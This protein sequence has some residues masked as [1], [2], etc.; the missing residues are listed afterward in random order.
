[1]SEA[2]PRESYLATNV[3][4]TQHAS[5]RFLNAVWQVFLLIVLLGGVEGCLPAHADEAKT[6]IAFIDGAAAVL[7]PDSAGE[8]KF[9]VPLK[10]SGTGGSAKLTLLAATDASCKGAVL[11]PKTVKDY[12]A[13]EVRIEPFKI[14]PVKLPAT[15][16]IEI[17][18]DGEDGSSSLKQVKLNQTY[19]KSG[20]LAALGLSFLVS[21]VVAGLGWLPARPPLK[22][23]MGS[24]AW[25]FAKSW[26]ST[27]TLVG[28]IISTALAL[29]ALPDLTRYASKSGY[30]ILALFISFVVVLAPF[31]FTAFRTGVL[32]RDQKTGAWT[33]AYEG[34]LWA[35][36]LSCAATIF[37]GITQIVVFFLLLHEIFRGYSFWSYSANLDPIS[38]N[39]GWVATL[40]LT[41]VLCIYSCYSIFLTVALQ[42]DAKSKTAMPVVVMKNETEFELQAAPPPLPSWPLL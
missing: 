9:D 5:V 1:L 3:I 22:S 13:N 33:V 8:F 39:L 15:C 18:S 25:D 11:E 6:N 41:A 12:V 32:V 35:L 27:T 40:G 42:L 31:I 24:P 16:F 4:P 17:I 26:T 2:Q 36:L 7:F 21:L 23:R 37:A 34:P 19:V 29:S 14:T 38:D 30:A 28:A 20:V 10:N